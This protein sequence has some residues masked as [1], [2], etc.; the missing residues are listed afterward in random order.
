M[1]EDFKWTDYDDTH[2]FL[3]CVCRVGS[4][5]ICLFSE[6]RW[7]YVDI[8]QNMNNLACGMA[9]CNA[10][11][12]MIRA[13]KYAENRLKPILSLINDVERLQTE[14]TKL[15]AE[16]EALDEMHGNLFNV[17]CYYQSELFDS[18]ALLKTVLP[19]RRIDPITPDKEVSAAVKV[20][21]DELLRL[22]TE[23]DEVLSLMTGP[24]EQYKSALKNCTLADLVKSRFVRIDGPDGYNENFDKLTLALNRQNERLVKLEVPWQDGGKMNGDNSW[25]MT[26]LGRDVYCVIDSELHKCYVCT[27]R[28]DL[29]FQPYDHYEA[30]TDGWEW[31]D[32]NKW[33][34][35]HELWATLPC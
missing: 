5:E 4:L 9:I 30:P 15:L 28:G 35:L 2:N 34:Q 17:A 8:K 3:H 25:F 18:A 6:D 27:V 21:V 10:A 19:S 31:K 32:V 26:N 23:R 20:V 14:N 33:C 13:K 22:Q 1:V 16:N 12:T 24:L 7:W 29:R 11:E